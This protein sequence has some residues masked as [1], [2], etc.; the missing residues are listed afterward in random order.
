MGS[1]AQV[2][3][4]SVCEYEKGKEGIDFLLTGVVAFER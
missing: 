2:L 3:F 1:T 4:L